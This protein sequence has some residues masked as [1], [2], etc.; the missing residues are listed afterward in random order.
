LNAI[1][2][3][4]STYYHNYYLVHDY[5]TGLWH[6]LPWDLDKTFSFWHYY[7][8]PQY[9][10]SGHQLFENVNKLV[11]RC[12]LHPQIR[13]SIKNDIQWLKE[14]FI[15]D[16]YFITM[17]DSL[18]DL[19]FQ[20]VDEDTYKN[21][22]T[23]E[24]TD[25]LQGLR[26]RIIARRNSVE[27]RLREDPLPFD[28]DEAKLTPG[29]I[30]LE[31]YDTYVENGE[32]FYWELIIS[33]ESTFDS[34]VKV[35][36]NLGLNR[37]VLEDFEPGKF[38]WY[39]NA[40][41]SS[42]RRVRSISYFKTF[43]IP[44]D[45]WTGTLVPPVLSTNQTW[46][47]SGSPYRLP[48][49]LIIPPNRVLRIEKGVTVGIGSER[50]IWVLGGLNVSGIEQDSVQFIPLEPGTFWG[51]I[52]PKESTD[53]VTF[54]HSVFLNGGK[55]PDGEFENRVFQPSWVDFSMNDCRISNAYLEGKAFLFISS[56]IHLE[57]VQVSDFSSAVI[58]AIGGNSIVI[59]SCNFINSATDTDHSDMID[60]SSTYGEV[61]ISNCNFY[62]GLDD[63]IDLDGNY[64]TIIIQ[65][66]HITGMGDHGISI[67]DTTSKVLIYNNFISRCNGAGVNVKRGASA[68]IYNNVLENNR[69]GI[70]RENPLS[71]EDGKVYVKNCIFW[72]NISDLDNI[73]GMHLD[74]S[75]CYSE[76]SPLPGEGNIS[77][78]LYANSPHSGDFRLNSF[79]A[80]IDAGWGTDYPLKDYN[81]AP[82]VDDPGSANSGSGEITYVDIGMFEYSSNPEIIDSEEKLYIQIYPNPFNNIAHINFPVVEESWAIVEIYN[83]LGQRIFQ[84]SFDRIS[85]G[86]HN[87]IWSSEASHQY[88]GS[89]TY[90]FRV[91]QSNFEK[92]AKFVLVH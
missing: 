86:R 51:S 55:G 61:E 44:E 17:T 65:R 5:D 71:I 87:I 39:V 38:Y 46:T 52:N 66:N 92:T 32:D 23:E 90:F 41:S 77:S 80:L 16:E 20:A 25:G 75:H 42:G 14:S 31:W 13:T 58:M 19:L 59:R 24:F 62:F 50:S 22:S 76:T 79:S 27:T 3:N 81:F 11:A 7:Q 69:Y 63:A 36:S 4:Q 73:P 74:V 29:G 57:N 82:R 26:E 67:G 49:G 56:N 37:L 47:K 60:I 2:G 8:N 45:Y 53:S 10:R 88:Y 72:E 91:R 18:H 48:E 70:R 30:N 35:I 15:N 28:L 83:I 12:W 34:D 1:I 21:Y 54:S 68:D 43:T 89:G 78:G 40:I 85:V 6:W 9:Y 64:G 84:R 33:P